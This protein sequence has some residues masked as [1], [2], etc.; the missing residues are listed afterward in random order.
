VAYV[1]GDFNGDGTDDLVITT[2]SGSFEYTG[3]GAGSFTPNVW[4]R[5]DLV[6]HQTAFFVGEFSG[7]GRD[8]LIIS[9]ASGSF[10]YLGQSGGGFTP[11]AWVRT[12]L[13]AAAVPYF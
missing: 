2:A 6:L 5:T 3:L 11:N 13:P 8:D 7:D 9:T 4:V 12:D 10:E 1:V